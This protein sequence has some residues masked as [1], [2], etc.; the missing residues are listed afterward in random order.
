MRRKYML[1]KQVEQ[2]ES[3][4][5]MHNAPNRG[6]MSR[7]KFQRHDSAVGGSNSRTDTSYYVLNLSRVSTLVRITNYITSQSDPHA[8][9]TPIQLIMLC[10]YRI[11]GEW[12]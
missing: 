5:T 3:N 7:A 2:T 4:G 6:R 11:H 10:T 8:H 1:R 9:R 12:R